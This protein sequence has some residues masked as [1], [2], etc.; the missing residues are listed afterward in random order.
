[1]PVE[2]EALGVCRE[3]EVRREETRVQKNSTQ[4]FAA[5]RGRGLHR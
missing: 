4:A 1:M 5:W 3:E 2:N